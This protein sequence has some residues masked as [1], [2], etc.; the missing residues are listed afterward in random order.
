LIRIAIRIWQPPGLRQYR[1]LARQ[2]FRKTAFRS[3]GLRY[4]GL[5][6]IW[7]DLRIPQRAWGS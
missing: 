3:L 4:V 5:V 7:F 1:T 2:V 6:G